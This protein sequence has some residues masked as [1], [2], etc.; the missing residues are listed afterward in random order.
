M[1]FKYFSTAKSFGTK[2]S[3][4]LVKRRRPGEGERIEE[5]FIKPSKQSFILY[6][7]ITFYN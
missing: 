1:A 3:K 5:K 2:G 6:F 7:I 4:I